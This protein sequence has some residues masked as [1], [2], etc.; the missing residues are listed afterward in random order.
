MELSP[1]I[2]VI[3]TAIVNGFHWLERL[4]ST[5]DYPVEE[6]V[7]I[8]NNGRGELT[9][10][11]NA[12][13]KIKHPFIDKIHICHMP[14]NIGCSG[15]WNLII[16]SYV[17]SPY[18]IILNH[19]IALSPGFLESMIKKAIPENIGMV[20]C[21]A[22]YDGLGSFE[23]FLIK[24]WVVEKIGLFDENYYPAYLEDYD[25]LQ[26][27][28]RSGIERDL[29]VDVPFL[30]GET[31]YKDSGSQTWRTEPALKEKLDAGRIINEQYYIGKWGAHFANPYNNAALPLSFSQ[32]SINLCKLKTLGF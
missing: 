30:H 27:L 24:S 5:I 22:G 21:S 20:H 26:R 1:K 25:Y 8:D 13:A 17:T 32:Y 31:E 15:A 28:W 2:P 3:G 19:D 12:L 10:Q 4:I 23:G 7:I 14:R 18:W 16:K 6:F 9:D 29:S 11:L